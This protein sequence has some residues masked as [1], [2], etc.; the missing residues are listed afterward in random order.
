MHSEQLDQLFTALSKVQA[1]MSS[2]IKDNYNPFHKSKYADLTAVWNACREPL[3]KNGFCV[4]QSIMRVEGENSLVTFLGHSSGQWMKSIAPI[5]TEKKDPQSFGIAVT[6]QRRY[7]LSAIV[8][9]C[10]D[11]DDGESAMQREPAKVVDVPISELQLSIL[12]KLSVN[13]SEIG[14]AAAKRF[15]VARKYK[16]LEEV[17]ERDFYQIKK[18]LTENQETKA[19]EV[20]SE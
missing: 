8:G 19:S 4:T 7:A 14:K 6:Y 1:E 17:I 13:L 10:V 11:D 2:A 20:I 18:I 12:Q 3:T 9:V 5:N 16:N 15:C